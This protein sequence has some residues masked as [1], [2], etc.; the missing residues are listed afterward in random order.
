VSRDGAE[1]MSFHVQ[2]QQQAVQQ[3]HNISILDVWRCCGFVV[4]LQCAIW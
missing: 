1:V 4:V 2:Q 3:V